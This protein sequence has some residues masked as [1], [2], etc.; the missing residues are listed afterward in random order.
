[1]R[2][3]IIK[4]LSVAL[5]ISVVSCSH[6]KPAVIREARLEAVSYSNLK[7][8]EYDDQL[9]G[10]DAFR[11]SCKAILKKKP[12]QPISRLTSLGG[13]V[14]DWL[15]VCKAATHTHVVNSKQARQFFEHW[16]RP[17]I[18]SD[19]SG[20]PEGKFTG[21][22]EIELRGSRCKTRDCIHPVYAPPRDIH[23]H[24]G[25]PHF[26][27]ASINNGCL[28]NKGLEIAYVDDK[29]R[30]FFMH[31]Q[32]SGV[33]KMDDG[34]ELKVGY[35]EQN[36]HPY[37]TIGPLFKN[38]TKDRIGSAT[39]MMEWMCRNKKVALKI[40]EENPS[41][42]FFRELNG[43]GPVGGQGVALTAE[44]SL[45]IDAKLYPYGTPVW[46]ETTTPK[47]PSFPPI[48]YSRIF[49]AQDTGGA[50]KGAVRADIFYGRGRDAEELA[51]YMNNKGRYYM[52]F[53][54]NIDIPKIYHAR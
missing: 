46:V 14:K 24:K 37:K 3:Y 12:E 10:L 31:I 27:H 17:Y 44:R 4:L 51:G 48:E 6:K 9:E 20:N 36:G 5:L 35:A 28:N 13:K 40:M 43:D 25:K 45:A 21:Y 18:V 7:H 33:V 54:K 29:A 41:Y 39:D 2:N 22:Y 49:V 15:P 16:F 26:T 34:R 38:Y 8:W 32:G 11:K 42:V 50:I 52:L 47:I 53:P 23:K 30:L 19:K 1:M